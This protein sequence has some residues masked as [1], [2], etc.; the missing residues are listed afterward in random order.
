MTL[1]PRER[2]QLQAALNLW[3]SVEPGHETALLSGYI[4]TLGHEPLDRDEVVALVAKLNEA[5]DA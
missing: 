4:R 1:S 3:L 5:A 2:L